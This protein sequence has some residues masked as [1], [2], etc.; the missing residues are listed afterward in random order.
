MLPCKFQTAVPV[1][2]DASSTGQ[3]NFFIHLSTSSFPHI[4]QL[5]YHHCL[6]LPST[7][8]LFKAPT[9]TSNKICFGTGGG[10]LC[11]VLRSL[12]TFRNVCPIAGAKTSAI[13]HCIT[14]PLTKAP[15]STSNKTCLVLQRLVE[16][17]CGDCVCCGRSVMCAL[18]RGRLPVLK[19]GHQRVLLFGNWS[20]LFIACIFNAFHRR[21]HLQRG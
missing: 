2:R 11:G 12:W 20:Y 3:G 15:T 10:R 7:I 8:Y 6:E 9:S 16:G 19:S 5:F 1:I 18:W 4:F 14:L 17:V 21:T 13:H